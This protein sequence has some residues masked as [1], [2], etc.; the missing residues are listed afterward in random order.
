MRFAWRRLA[1]LACSWLLTSVVVVEAQ[2]GGSS[3]RGRIL[4]PQQAVLPGVVLIITH[5]ESGVSRETV[6][7]GEGTYVIPGLVPGPYRITAELTGFSKFTRE[8][9]VLEIGS[10][11]TVDLPM[12]VGSIEENITVTGQAAQIDLTTAQGGGQISGAELTNLPS[13][14][15]GIAVQA[16]LLPGVQYNP[17][18]SP[19]SDSI[20][21]N[22]QNAS[23]VNF[24]ID[25][26][27][28]NDDMRGG[29]AGAQARPSLESIQE[30]QV[31]TN[32]FDAE[33]GRSTGG[34]VNAVTKQ[35]TNA[36]RGSAFGFFTN[37]GM[38]AENFF[39]ARDGGEKPN[40]SKKQYGMTFGGPIVRDRAHFFANFERIRQLQGITQSYPSRPDKSF[41]A[42][43]DSNF[44][45][46]SIRVDHQITRAHNYSVR[47]LRDYQP[48][49]NRVSGNPTIDGRRNEW[50]ADKNAILNFNSIFGATRLNS[51]RVAYTSEV[52]HQGTMQF[53]DTKRHDLDP[54][55]VQHL[56]YYDGP[57]ARAEQRWQISYGF[58]DTL[59][60]V[61]RN[62]DLKMGFQYVKATHRIIDQHTGNGIFNIPTDRD[63]NRADPSTYPERLTIRVP[64]PWESY[65]YT[66]S[67]GLFVQ[68]K[69]ALTPKFTLSLG[70]RYDVDVAPIPSGRFNPLFTSED[71]Y[72][73]D[74]NNIQPR[75]G[76]AYS[77]GNGSVLR[78]GFGIFY[79]KL[80]TDRFEPYVQTGVFSRT[81][82]TNFPVDRADPG[83][84]AGRLP[85][86]PF[87]VNG[88][89]VN[90]Q[91]LEQ[92][93]PPGTLVRNT[94]IVYLDTPERQ[95]PSVR[96][97]TLGYERMLGPS[98]SMG[99]DVI[100]SWG[101]N[102]VLA[103][104]LNPGLRVDTSRTGVINRQDFMGL[105]RQLAISPFVNDVLIRETI[106]E[107]RYKG[108]NL[109]LQ[110]RSSGFWG[111]RVAYTIGSATD[112]T[113]GGPTA[114]NNFQVL[115]ERNLEL[116]EGP[117]DAD[118]RHLLT[119]SGNVTV[120]GTRGLSVSGVFRAM[121]GRPIT[122]QD[123]SRDPDRNGR[124]F[125]PLPAGT[126]SGVGPDALTVE[127]AGGRNGA[128]GP[129]FVQLD[130]RFSYQLFNANRRTLDVF[131]E[132]FNLANN[133]DFANP[134]GD[135]R[136]S[137]FL[138]PTGLLAGGFPR[139]LQ[140]GA[141]LGF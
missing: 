54:P 27:N 99:I 42:P 23:Q 49:F 32:Q 12:T 114:V 52:V 62:H 73:V 25:G 104:N 65:V 105:A 19:A 76:L 50:D 70:L 109:Q 7:S 112:N 39:V 82:L 56:G 60:W 77:A 71:D 133:V 48:N 66:H 46:T 74:R 121:S 47:W 103:Y 33:F 127:N 119:L 4:D 69:W 117:A 141:R 15:R 34:I 6:S 29:S 111:A 14:S 110:K 40:S 20:N 130:V 106:G 67:S 21:V 88:P 44:Y 137:T 72:P 64:G 1:W 84:S 37:K 35:G 138:V 9:V 87:L 96:Q 89:V 113:G 78:G 129:S 126:Y 107:S 139:Q 118:R 5:Q 26:G 95:I 101:V 51:I 18:E 28:N 91:L 55:T 61:V 43:T 11:L 85:T 68:D 131:G 136:L 140:F 53:H 134:S 124:L 58:D 93:F 79:E 81:F 115:D 100:N 125:D 45:N 16:A 41:S 30:F 122:L 63:F 3:V 17:S 108:L 24:V 75:I 123:S 97:A 31:I 128:W 90:R 38:T 86:D 120:P 59:S 2:S 13:A 135:R 116:N 92:L 94:G 22:G 10:T 36:Y 57:D 80:W 102:Q 8:N 98:L 132:V 83:P